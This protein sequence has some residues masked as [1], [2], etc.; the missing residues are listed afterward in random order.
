MMYTCNQWYLIFC[1]GHIIKLSLKLY[2]DSQICFKPFIY[3]YGFTTSVFL[4]TE[5]FLKDN[6]WK[7]FFLILR[8][9][10]S[11]SKVLPYFHCQKIL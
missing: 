4:D 7:I 8:L 5:N 1:P 3:I 2:S 10:L 6:F 11:P 9:E